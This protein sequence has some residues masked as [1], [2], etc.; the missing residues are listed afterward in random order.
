LSG[1]P[2]VEKNGYLVLAVDGSAINISTTEENLSAY[3]NASRKN[4]K[5]QAQL[6]IS[7]ERGSYPF[8]P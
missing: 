1:Y 7:H 6:G 5:P 8:H 2:N 3:G 4:A